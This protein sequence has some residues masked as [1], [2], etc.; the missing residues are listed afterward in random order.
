MASYRDQ[1]RSR[2]KRKSLPALQKQ[3]IMIC[4]QKILDVLQQVTLESKVNAAENSHACQMEGLAN[5]VVRTAVLSA[6]S[7]YFGE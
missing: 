3:I 4:S 2:A 5:V 7:T 1:C 6:K